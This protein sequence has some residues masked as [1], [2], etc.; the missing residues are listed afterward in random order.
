MLKYFPLLKVNGSYRRDWTNFQD[1]A[2]VTWTLVGENLTAT[3]AGGAGSGYSTIQDE[4]SSVTQ[5]TTLNFVGAGVAVADSGGKTVVTIS[6]TGDV[7]SNTSTS[8]DS[9]VA[10]F[11]GTGGKTLKR[12]S[13]TGVAKLT[14]GVLSVGTVSLSS[15]VTGNLPVTNLNSGTS[16]SSST[17]WRGDG[18]WATPST[19]SGAQ[20][21]FTVGGADT[22][23]P[24]ASYTDVGDAINAA[25]AALP[26]DGG[27]IFVQSGTYTYTT[28]IVFGTNNKYVSLFGANASST[29]LK[30]S[31]T[32]GNAIT[33]NYGNPT[34]HI[35]SE[36]TGIT[37]M[38]KSSLIAAGVANTNTSVGIYYGG[39]NG[40]VGINTHD[41]NVNGFGSNWEIGQ[42]AYMLSFNNCG[43]SGGNGGQAARGS[44]VHINAANDSGERNVFNQCNFTDPGNSDADN[45][46]YITN[47]GTASNFFHMCSIDSAQVTVG[48]SNGTTT[49]ISNH[50]E[51]PGAPTAYAEYIPILGVSSDS[52]TQI[53]LIGN[54]FANSASNQTWTTIVRH[55]GQIYA[56]GN[57]IDN[58]NGN[59]VTNFILHDLNNGTSSDFV[60]QTQVQGGALTNIIGGSGGMTHS[61]ATGVGW[62]ANVANSYTI[63]IRPNSSNV[64]DIFSGNSTVATF[65][66]DGNWVFGAGGATNNVRL[67]YNNTSQTV[68]GIIIN[69]SDATGS[70]QSVLG[71]YSDGTL[72]GDFRADGNG[73]VGFDSSGSGGMDFNYN[74][75]TGAFTYWGGTTVEKFK[76][77]ND[78]VVSLYGRILGV[79]ASIASANNIT[80]GNANAFDVTGTTQINTIATTGWTSGSTIT[81]RFSTSV[82]IAHNTAGTGAVLLLSGAANFSATA[83]DSLMLQYDGTSW[84]E[85][86]RTV[87]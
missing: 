70:A 21:F 77:A 7:S 63:G 44:L 51:N 11:S 22:D 56:V 12:A 32:S 47:A 38:G 87:I 20:L 8:V 72:R 61:R 3:A 48:A 78:G 64:N 45:A 52:S 80:L 14:S 66:H 37:L 2:T 49:F 54:E 33:I 85:V 10:I 58:Y 41:M 28:P 81:L 13:G 1:S 4:G 75:G 16:A 55:G 69:S 73:N 19:G 65:D 26:S 27:G 84:R 24:V 29:F 46:I 39:A 30:Y 53:T 34:G 43:N 6:A 68:P 15:E 60:T 25:Y 17:F 40:A 83:D 59:T 5:R 71:L 9:E 35:V 18:T 76:V 23:Y 67:N 86:S 42:H 79:A 50:F 82:T 31:P 74:T 62:A 57:H 36:I